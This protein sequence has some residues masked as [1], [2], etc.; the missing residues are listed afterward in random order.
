MYAHD[1]IVLAGI[2][3]GSVRGI[4]LTQG[5]IAIVD[6]EDYEWLMQ[7]KWGAR[8]DAWNCYA[9]RTAYP[10]GRNGTE[11]RNHS[12]ITVNMHREIMG[13]KPKDG[14]IVDHINRNC[15]DNRKVNLRIAAPSINGYN[16]RMHRDN[17]SGYRG[18]FWHKKSRKWMAQFLY[19]GEHIYCG[20]FNNL[21][22]AVFAYDCAIIKYRGEDAILN[23]PEKR[24]EY[25]QLI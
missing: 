17:S 10:N 16:C 4:P 3:N 24:S 15:L 6:D 18:V 12:N 14:I 19:H 9:S 5:K 23:F 7:W 8:H 22:D 20:S 1:A 2:E 25:E 11:G 21:L 13:C